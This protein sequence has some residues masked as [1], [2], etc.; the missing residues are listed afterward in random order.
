MTS[1]GEY[2]RLYFMER[3]M[4][5]K[6]TWIWEREEKKNSFVYFRKKF[7]LSKKPG[8][9]LASIA[10]ESKYW[11]YVNGR[12]VVFD[13][14]LKRGPSP[15]DT[16][17]DAV[18]LAPYL[19][20]GENTI[21]ALVCYFGEKEPAAQCFSH[22]GA[23]RAGFLFELNTPFGRVYSDKSWK[24]LRNPAYKDS[25]SFK[26]EDGEA[27]YPQPNYRLPEYDGF[28][29]AASEISGA[30]NPDFD[31]C[32]WDYAVEI[33]KAGG[34]PWNNLI[35][36]PIPLLKDYGLKNFINSSAF[37]GK[38]TEREEEFKLYLP[39]NAQITP[40]LDIEAEE[41]GKVVEIFSEN[42]CGWQGRTLMNRLSTRKGR[43]KAE[44]LNWFNGQ[45]ITFKFPAGIRINELKYRESGYDAEFTGR[46]ACEDEVLNRLWT[47]SARTLYITMRDNYMDCP[48][49]ERAQWWG[50]VTSEMLI[51][52]YALDTKSYLLY[53][54]G[55]DTLVNWSNEKFGG[56]MQTVV[57]I[58]NA[59]FELPLQ[60]LAG[61]CGFW[62]YYRYTGRAEIL[63]KTFDLSVKYLENWKVAEGGVSH[64]PGTWDWQDWGD[65]FD[66]AL[67]DTAWY[68]FALK[69][70]IG[71][72]RVLGREYKEL[73]DKAAA[74]EKGFEK[75]FYRGGCYAAEGVE[76][77]DRANAV[78]LLCGLIPE[79]R[80]GEIQKNVFEKVFNSSPYM[81]RYVLEAMCEAGFS[82][83]AAER[84]K[85]RYRAMEKFT[86]GGYK[87]TTLWE[88]WDR[89]GGTMNHAWSGA[90]LIVL[91]SRFAGIVPLKP[92][93]EEIEIA[94]AF[95]GLNEIDTAF[96]TV[97]GR[98]EA[99]IY[100]DR[101]EV[102]FEAET[103]KVPVRIVL[104]VFGGDKKVKA[105]NARLSG[106]EKGKMIFRSEGG[107][108]K[109]V[110]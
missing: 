48:D 103:P 5:D 89:T 27:L 39:Y 65:K 76:A 53:E 67:L 105:S 79:E 55:V 3:F 98:I 96:D 72:A 109:I 107:K 43:Q 108:I 100:L 24:A 45:E 28:Y 15:A 16:Y 75:R 11:L 71:A 106:E 93:W 29:D 97:K 52:M 102:F 64:Y 41:D 60:M 84:M 9:A 57:P 46:F 87:Y 85:N 69:S 104:P 7:F 88:L 51:T 99:R 47:M 30:E 86:I 61:I 12:N 1:G 90:P 14:Q 82:E 54:K 31:D 10:A 83:K 91:S 56:K 6:A 49:R 32:G 92:G 23:G 62:D 20:K 66:V 70:L 18:D 13:G 95:G 36:R 50:D 94:P 63:E 40:Y 35:P 37:A 74:I 81:E 68:Y 77:D 25:S 73:K 26:G 110:Y 17:F 22:N 42:L 21:L 38:Y 4:F 8:E 58:K 2:P 80:Y 19:K 59:Q 78:A 44:I 101:G 33:V 34:E